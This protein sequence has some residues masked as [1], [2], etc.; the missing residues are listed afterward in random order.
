MITEIFFILQFSALQLFEQHRL[1]QSLCACDNT[2]AFDSTAMC[3]ISCS[4][5]TTLVKLLY[6]GAQGSLDLEIDLV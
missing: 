4:N 2:S 1:L 3:N 5:M 6:T